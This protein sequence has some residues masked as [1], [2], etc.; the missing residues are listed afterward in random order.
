MKIEADWQS[1][2]H[3]KCLSPS[4]HVTDY[5]SGPKDTKTKGPTPMEVMLEAAAC[6]SGMDII[7]ILQKKRKE[8][9]EF[10]IVVEG[11]RAENHPKR[12]TSINITYIL[13]KDGLTEKDAEQ[14]VKLSVEKYCSVTASLAPDM[15]I[16][17]NYEL[18]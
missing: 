13:K 11:E 4:N 12:F 1:G 16:N 7:S 2:M 15:D 14:A 18:K 5:D 17:W 10:K 9:E 6:C 8:P 3:F